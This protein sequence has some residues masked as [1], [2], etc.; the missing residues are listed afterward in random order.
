MSV[1]VNGFAQHMV[2]YYLVED[3]LAGRLQ[4]PSTIPDLIA[5]EISPEYL[6]QRFRLPLIVGVGP[7]GERKYW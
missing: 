1:N 5:L 6:H 2:S 4:T 3:V 7:D